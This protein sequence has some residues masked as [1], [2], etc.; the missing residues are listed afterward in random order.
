MK[1]HFSSVFSPEERP[2][3]ADRNLLF[4]GVAAKV[5]FLGGGGKT[6]SI[7]KKI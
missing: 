6:G 4:S 7:D 1:Q 2:V 5:G 3:G